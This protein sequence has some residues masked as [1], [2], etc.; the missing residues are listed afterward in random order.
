[1]LLLALVPLYL[2]RSAPEAPADFRF[3]R[4]SLPSGGSLLVEAA[5]ADQQWGFLEDFTNGVMAMLTRDLGVASNTVD[6]SGSTHSAG[7]FG[8]SMSTAVW[9][10]EGAVDRDVLE[11][12]LLGVA[13]DSLGWSEEGQPFAVR[14]RSVNTSGPESPRNLVF[15]DGAH[16]WVD[17]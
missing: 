10:P 7:P 14:Y 8:S 4:S 13:I 17:A 15:L 5:V 11:S 3:H 6:S 2:S 9:C 1:M 16:R 12:V